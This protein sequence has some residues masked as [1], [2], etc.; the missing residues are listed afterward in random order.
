LKGETLK[1]KKTIIYGPVNSRRLGSSLGL[2]ILPT[3]YK[4]CPFNCAYCQYGFTG[5]MGHVVDSDG[6]DMP[7]VEEVVAALK[8]AFEEYPSVSY[9]TFS[10]NGEPT[11]HPD[12]LNIVREVKKLKDGINPGIRLAILSNSSLVYKAEVREGL[13]LLDARFMKLDTGDEAT[14]QR[15]NRPRE[16][17]SLEKIVSGLKQLENIII[18]SLFAGGESGNSDK[19]SIDC[20][21][22]KI[23][24]IRPMEC[25]IYS[26][27]R[28]AADRSLVQ[29]D[30]EG[31]T[32]IKRKTDERVGVSVK[33]F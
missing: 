4:A 1:L 28:P 12:F 14:F 10:G 20:W 18:Q 17:I 25:H 27:D 7:G 32:E 2:N 19:R 9:I 24:E 6:A 11:L 26:L 3:G 29:I 5:G 16:G 22:E 13:A 23:G 31:L 15:F 8:K 33:V 21:I 30:R